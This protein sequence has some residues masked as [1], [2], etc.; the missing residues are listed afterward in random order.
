MTKSSCLAV[1]MLL[2]GSSLILPASSQEQVSQTVYVYDGDFNGTLLSGVQVAGQDAAGKSF[3]GITD[4]NGVAAVSGQPGTWLFVFIKDGYETLDLSYNV[5]ETGEGAVYLVRSEEPQEQIVPSLDNQQL[6]AISGPTT[7]D[8]TQLQ[9]SATSLGLTQPN[10]E[11]EQRNPTASQKIEI[12]EPEAASAEFWLEKGNSLY[13]QGRYDEA[14]V[15]YDKSIMQDPQLEAS[16]FNKGNALYMQGDY[17]NALL[18]FDRAIEINPQDANAWICKGLTLKKLDRTL[19]ANS[20]LMQ[21]K[22]LGYTG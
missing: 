19:E 17:H 14:A 7:A 8:Q 6:A 5:T 22:E 10:Q 16:W 21:A 20:A 12:D 9:A 11:Q 18:A 3:S 4:S 15:S 13:E 2:I 1:L